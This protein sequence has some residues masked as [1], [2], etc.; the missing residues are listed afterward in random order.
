MFS[1]RA[2]ASRADK[3]L[4]RSERARDAAVAASSRAA[5]S[6]ALTELVVLARL[7][8]RCDRADDDDCLAPVGAADLWALGIFVGLYFVVTSEPP[9]PPAGA[10]AALDADADAAADDAEEK[11]VRLL[12]NAESPT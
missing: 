9:P 2:S 3:R 10:L 11:D 4:R 8:A 1:S 5:T 6:A 12:L 7:Y